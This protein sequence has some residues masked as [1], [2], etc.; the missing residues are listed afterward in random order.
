MF[1]GKEEEKPAVVEETNERSLQRSYEQRT[2]R[3]QN[4]NRGGRSNEDRKPREERKRP[5]KIAVPRCP[6]NAPCAKHP[7]ETHAGGSRVP[8][9]LPV[10]PQSC[11][12]S[13]TRA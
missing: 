5:V 6:K 13:T 8:R 9:K 10:A 11:E 4:R 1:A 3:Q 12:E 2:G 7:T